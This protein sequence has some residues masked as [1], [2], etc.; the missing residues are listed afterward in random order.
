MTHDHNGN[1][2]PANSE[3][4][5]VR[6]RLIRWGQIFDGFSIPLHPHWRDVVTIRT[7]DGPA[8]N[9]DRLV[10]GDVMFSHCFVLIIETNRD[11]TAVIFPEQLRWLG[12]PPPFGT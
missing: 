5:S 9:A 7:R 12:F 1:E 2:N 11:Q 6:L 8:E 10:I 4:Q 3:V